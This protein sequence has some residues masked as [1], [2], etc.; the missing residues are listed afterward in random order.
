MGEMNYMMVQ[1]VKSELQCIEFQVKHEVRRIESGGTLS[2]KEF[3]SK[4]SEYF[5]LSKEVFEEILAISILPKK[6]SRLNDTGFVIY[7]K[8]TMGEI[9]AEGLGLMPSELKTA[10]I[11]FTSVE[12]EPLGEDNFLDHEE[13][14]AIYIPD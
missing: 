10:R 1:I 14:A 13:I 5:N 11:A 4:Y 2:Q 8:N 6:L 12:Q 7:N 9:N 3:T